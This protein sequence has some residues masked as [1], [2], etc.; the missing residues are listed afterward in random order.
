[1]KKIDIL[2][3]LFLT[4]AVTSSAQIANWKVMPEYDSVRLRENGLVE[5]SQNGKHGLLDSEGAQLLPIAYDSIGAFNCNQALLFNDSKFVGFVNPTGKKV[6]TDPNYTLV[7]DMEFFSEGFLPVKK[8]THYYFLDAEGSSVAGPFAGIQPYFSGYAAVVCYEDVEKKPNDVYNAYINRNQVLAHIREYGKKDELKRDDLSF[9]SSFRDGKAMYI[10]KRKGYMLTDSLTSTPI[11]SD[12]LASKKTIVQFDKNSSLNPVEGGY[13]LGSK[14]GYLYFN[15]FNQLDKIENAGVNLFVYNAPKTEA[16]ERVTDLTA[17]GQTGSM[18]VKYKGDVV[19][20]EQFAEVIPLDGRFAAVKPQ[21]KWGIINIDTDNQIKLRLNNNEHIGFNH[22]YFTAKLAASMPS[23]I[24]CNNATIVSK[25]DD[26][27]IQIDS[28]H[29]NDNIERNTLTY[30]CRLSIPPHLTDTLSTQEYTYALKYNGFTSIDYKVQIPQWYVK[31]YEVALSNNKFT[32]APNDTISVEFDL[33]KTDVARNDETNYFKTVELITNEANAIPLNKI[34]ENH[35]GFRIG[36]IDREKLAFV[37][38][39][40]E[41]G[42]PSIEY[43]FEMLFEKPEPKSNRK[44]VDVTVSPVREVP[45][46]PAYIFENAPET[47]PQPLPADSTL[48][49]APA[50]ATTAATPAVSA[51]ATTTTTTPAAPA[52]T[53]APAAPAAPATTPVNS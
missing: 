51:P 5:V 34:T 30:D 41:V 21:D 24:K 26:C 14:T 2:T 43:P 40:T 39:I 18:G 17:F 12:S 53:P 44:S 25:S 13:L 9:I 52:T 15:K 4:T 38:R 42:C 31:Y 33:L 46:V 8:G 11:A 3:A 19:L 37:V 28:R 10:Y 47:Q 22:R 7:P 20:P 32:L 6:E 35:Y 45:G 29:E 27:E 1:M 23:Y 36:G 49:S 16:V 48:M 50:P